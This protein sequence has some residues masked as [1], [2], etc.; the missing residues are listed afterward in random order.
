VWS[1]DFKGHLNT[2]D[3]KRREPLTV[4]D[5]E[6]RYLLKLVALTGIDSEL[7]RADRDPA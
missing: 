1:I 5:K 3:G 2:G 4:T 6:S 7:V